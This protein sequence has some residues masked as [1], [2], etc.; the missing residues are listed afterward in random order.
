MP[1]MSTYRQIH[2]SIIPRKRNFT[3]SNM[4][5]IQDDNAV[6]TPS[7]IARTSISVSANV[8]K[9]K[10]IDCYSDYCK[11]LGFTE[12]VTT[13][14][15]ENQQPTSMLHHPSKYP[16]HYQLVRDSRMKPSL[17]AQYRIDDLSLDNVIVILLHKYPNNFDPSDVTSLSQVNTLY[18]EMVTDVTGELLHYEA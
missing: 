3:N 1:G 18:N 7:A 14:K 17:D 11:T 9:N 2:D 8:D 12:S 16:S 10:V 4:V 5:V 15:G 13:K 6:E